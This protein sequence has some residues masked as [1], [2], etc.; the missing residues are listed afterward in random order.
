MNATRIERVE[1]EDP[2]EL[3]EP[4]LSAWNEPD[5]EPQRRSSRSP[6]TR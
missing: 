5:G 2:I 3:P 4:W 1:S 6:W